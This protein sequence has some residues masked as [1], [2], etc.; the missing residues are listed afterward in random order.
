M[1]EVWVMRL[2]GQPTSPRCLVW[3]QRAIGWVWWCYGIIFIELLHEDTLPV[4]PWIIPPPSVLLENSV[5]HCVCVS[6]G[7]GLLYFSCRRLNACCRFYMKRCLRCTLGCQGLVL[8]ELFKFT[9][10]L[11]APTLDT[12]TSTTAAMHTLMYQREMCHT[13]LSFPAWKALWPGLPAC[14]AVLWEL[15]QLNA[16]TWDEDHQESGWWKLPEEYKSCQIC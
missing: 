6:V 12:A 4:L 3:A 13:H 16:V 2:K 8:S 7:G 10:E 11:P 1:N 9:T 14:Q 15:R 5:L